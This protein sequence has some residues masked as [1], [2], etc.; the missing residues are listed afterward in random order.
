MK[1]FR[2]LS[3]LENQIPESHCDYLKQLKNSGFYPRVI[4][5]IGACVLHWTK[6]AKKVWPDARIILFEANE[7]VEFLYSGHEYFMGLLGDTDHRTVKYYYNDSFPTGNSYYKENSSVFPETTYRMMQIHSLDSVVKE[8]GFPLPDLI[9]IDVQGAEM[10]IIKGG[11]ETIQHAE[12][13]IVEMQC[14]EY[15]VGAPSVEITKPY[16]ESLGFT[17][18]DPLFTDHGPDGDYGFVNQRMK[19]EAVITT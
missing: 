4:Y 7:A 16:I 2:F 19:K 8:K 9:K 11:I 17:C 12:R 10:D 1:H 15:N 18:C 3:T 13:L 6:E 5:D 14:R